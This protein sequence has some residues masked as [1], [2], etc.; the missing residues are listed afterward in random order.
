M[1]KNVKPSIR[2]ASRIVFADGLIAR[3]GSALCTAR[4]GWA[5]RDVGSL[6]RLLSFLRQRGDLAIFGDFLFIPVVGSNTVPGLQD[7]R[8][9]TQVVVGGNAEAERM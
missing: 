9:K 4:Y 3:V 5:A 1:L 8:N 6:C 7:L 2:T